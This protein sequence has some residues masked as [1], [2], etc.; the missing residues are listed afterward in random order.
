[1][2][3]LE[4]EEDRKAAPPNHDE[5]EDYYE[6]EQHEMTHRLKNLQ[7]MNNNNLQ[8]ELGMTLGS[9]SEL[10]QTMSALGATRNF[11]DSFKRLTGRLNS[12]SPKQSGQ[13][14]PHLT[15]QNFG[16][17]PRYLGAK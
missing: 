13:Y 14:L 1:M 6:E 11:G 4:D 15:K 5:E 17:D 10:D 8:H 3:E 9:N 7:M 16:E 12:L 2:Q